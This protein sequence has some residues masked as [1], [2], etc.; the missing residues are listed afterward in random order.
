MKKLDKECIIIAPI[1][2]ANTEH[3]IPGA[4]SKI[5]ISR[6]LELIWDHPDF[7]FNYIGAPSEILA[8]L[9][10]MKTDFFVANLSYSDTLKPKKQNKKEDGKTNHSF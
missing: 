8:L 10:L 1:P 5:R 6:K 4:T 2:R 9:K 3:P 7:Y